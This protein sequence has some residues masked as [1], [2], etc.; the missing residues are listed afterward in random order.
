MATLT[1]PAGLRVELWSSFVSLLR[2]YAAA[3]N[4]NRCDPVL[5]EEAGDSVDVVAGTT[6]LTLRFD[7]PG[8]TVNWTGSGTLASSGSFE[9]LPEGTIAIAGNVQDLDHVAIGFIASVTH[10]GRGSR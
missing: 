4:L 7:F 9:F 3:A 6:C 2:S 10:A 1:E 5:V 8:A